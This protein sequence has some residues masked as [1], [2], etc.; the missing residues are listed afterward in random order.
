MVSFLQLP[1]IIVKFKLQH[2]VSDVVLSALRDTWK[3]HEEISVKK[4]CTKLTHPKWYGSLNFFRRNEITSSLAQRQPY[5]FVSISS[6][7]IVW[8][9]LDTICLC[10]LFL[11]QNFFLISSLVIFPSLELHEKKFN[12]PYFLL[13]GH[14]IL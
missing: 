11:A 3:F 5:S 12:Y 13:R 10:S 6:S 14:T 8:G 9:M 2:A 4:G 7:A 1:S